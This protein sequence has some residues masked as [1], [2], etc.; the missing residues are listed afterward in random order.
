MCQNIS[1]YMNCLSCFCLILTKTETFQQFFSVKFPN[2]KFQG[3]L[4]SKS[5]VVKYE[6]M[7]KAFLY[8]QWSDMN[9][10]ESR[11]TQQLM[12]Q[13]LL[14]IPAINL[15]QLPNRCKNS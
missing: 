1:F 8:M 2:I 3:N 10:P 9:V 7:D 5:G 14:L 12:K 13:T 11:G 4:F 15:K 6:Q